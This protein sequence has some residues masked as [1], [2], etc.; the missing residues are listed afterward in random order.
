MIQPRSSRYRVL[1]CRAA[2][3]IVIVSSGCATSPTGPYTPVTEANRQ[4]SLAERLTKEGADQM[5]DD[6]E[7][8]EK[9]LRQALTADLYY[10][11]AHNNL[12][13]LF[14][15]QGRLYDAANEFEWAKKLL[16]GHPDPRMNLAITLE[17]AGRVDEAIAM[18]GTALEV[19]P[20][21]I[22]TVQALTRLQVR[23]KRTDDRT[24]RF[25][26]EIAL[27]GETSEWRE[28]AKS[29]MAMAKD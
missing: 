12:G 6:P 13:V 9:L 4:S 27:R 11:P 2:A 22:P 14:L 20:D 29:R 25:L 26:Q 23:S 28:W 10:G 24:S 5:D 8:A 3:I 21:H 16:P 19:Y 7:K 17:S 18:Y 1:V 15:R